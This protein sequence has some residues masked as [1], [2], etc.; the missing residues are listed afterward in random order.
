MSY[1]SMFCKF[2]PVLLL[3][4][5]GSVLAQGQDAAA[6]ELEAALLLT[7]DPENGRKAYM[8]C[9]VCHR[10]EGWG[11]EDGRYPQIAG[12]LR[13]VIIKQLAD[14]RAR[15]RD[16]P[17]MRPFTSPQLLGGPQEIA[18]VAAYI[19]QLPMN[20]M[21]SVG[22]GANLAYGEQ[23]YKK[24]CADCHG[25]KGEGDEKD[26]I[27]KIHGQHIGY[28]VRQFEWIRI[29]KRRNADPKMVKQI[30][31]FTPRE[32]IAVLDYVAHLKPPA[33][34][35]AEPGWENP[36]FPK[37]S[38]APVAPPAPAF[39]PVTRLQRPQRP[40]PPPRP[41]FRPLPGEK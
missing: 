26:H 31:R 11:T 27:P 33:E 35:L 22:S 37:Y 41:E 30:R 6:R 34:K 18:D 16:N 2:I 25:A 9:T 40:E 21:N 3:A 39:R 14:I 24:E 36:D 7:P 13:S 29:G 5:S 28:L 19:E 4:G 23:I 32:E 12:Q 8:V 17:T 1:S 38:R 10:P 20:P 15:N